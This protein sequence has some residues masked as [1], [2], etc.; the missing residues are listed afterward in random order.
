MTPPLIYSIVAAASLVAA[1][2]FWFETRRMQRAVPRM[3]VTTGVVKEMNSILSDRRASHVRSTTIVNVEF[4]VSGKTYV[5]RTLRLF[6]GN[7]SFGDV[8]KK[9]D[10]APGQQVGV[11][12]DP[13][14]PRRSALIRDKPTY[15]SVYCA[16]IFA[17]I[18]GV[19][20]AVAA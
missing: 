15:N 7:W 4:V 13:T 8:G 14:D 2:V 17:A 19:M 6:S 20:A 5:C 1:V 9:F 10:L 18:F 3:I 12:Y 11:Y 16:I